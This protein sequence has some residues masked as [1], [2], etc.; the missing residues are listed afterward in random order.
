MEHK[1]DYIEKEDIR[2]GVDPIYKV[3][4]MESDRLNYRILSIFYCP[5]CGVEL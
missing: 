5:F 2:I 4:V 1:C 3:W